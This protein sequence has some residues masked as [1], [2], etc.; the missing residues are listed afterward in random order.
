[1]SALNTI[2]AAKLIRG[3]NIG[4]IENGIKEYYNIL[5]SGY[6]VDYDEVYYNIGLGYY[7]LG[8]VDELQNLRSRN[9]TNTRINRMFFYLENDEKPGNSSQTIPYKKDRERKFIVRNCGLLLA[10]GTLIA[11]F[12]L[13]KN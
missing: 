7:R 4:N 8:D 9:P 2:K 10:G 11:V 12:C 3:P 5:N 6:P 13:L 1:M